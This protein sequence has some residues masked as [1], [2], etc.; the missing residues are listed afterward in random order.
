MLEST[1]RAQLQLFTLVSSAIS[2]VLQDDTSP[3]S[4]YT[5]LSVTFTFCLIA[6]IIVVLIYDLT[7]TNHLAIIGFLAT[8]LILTSFSVSGLIYTSNRA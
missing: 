6:G 8:G 4:D 7:S 2:T 1:H 5:W 3:Y